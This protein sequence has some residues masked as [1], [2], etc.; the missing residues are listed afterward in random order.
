MLIAKSSPAYLQHMHL[1]LTS[2]RAKFPAQ[3]I[4]LPLI[5]RSLSQAHREASPRKDLEAV[6][7]MKVTIAVDTMLHSVI[8][9]S[10]AQGNRCFSLF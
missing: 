8:Q 9:Q 6:K 3:K 2:R 5:L 10:K 4:Y 7:L 1:P